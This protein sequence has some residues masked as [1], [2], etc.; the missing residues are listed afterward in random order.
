[1]INKNYKSMTRNFILVLRKFKVST[2]WS[3]KIS[4]GFWKNNGI[5]S[6]LR[7]KGTTNLCLHA[8]I[9]ILLINGLMRSSRPLRLGVKILKNLL[10]T[11]R[12]LMSTLAM[13]NIR[14]PRP[15]GQNMEPIR[16]SNFSRLAYLSVNPRLKLM[17][18]RLVKNSF[19]L[20]NL[21]HIILLMLKLLRW[22]FSK[23]QLLSSIR[24][25]DS[26]KF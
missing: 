14:L 21:N 26:F 4:R 9:N 7:K 19:R 5:A 24:I 18:P 22:D 1:M 15:L 10:L 3:R 20:W 23:K 11:G 8:V 17:N 12:K 2:S 6:W 25:S 13:S 16:W